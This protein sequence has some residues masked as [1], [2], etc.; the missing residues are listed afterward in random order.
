MYTKFLKYSPLFEPYVIMKKVGCSRTFAGRINMKFTDL[1]NLKFSAFIRSWNSLLVSDCH[2]LC[3]FSTSAKLR[4]NLRKHTEEEV[5]FANMRFTKFLEIPSTGILSYLFSN[6]KFYSILWL[7][8][9]K[10]QTLIL[11]AT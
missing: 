2:K 6:Y 10:F 5:S 11:I 1:W 8:Y 3:Y 4:L 7:N 9:P